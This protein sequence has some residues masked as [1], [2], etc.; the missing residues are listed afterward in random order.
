MEEEGGYIYELPE[1]PKKN[2]FAF[3]FWMIL[4]AAIALLAERSVKF[5]P[6]EG[7]MAMEPDPIKVNIALWHGMNNMQD[8]DTTMQQPIRW[9]P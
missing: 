2:R 4:G 3:L 5:I 6:Q 8:V 7:P 1:A 9:A